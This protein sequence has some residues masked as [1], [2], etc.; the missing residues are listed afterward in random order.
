MYYSYWMNVC[1]VVSVTGIRDVSPPVV[2]GHRRDSRFVGYTSAG[3]HWRRSRND[4]YRARHSGANSWGICRRRSRD[5]LRRRAQLWHWGHRSQGM[6]SICS[7]CDLVL[8]WC[9]DEAP[10]GR[11]RQM[12]CKVDTTA[13][14]ETFRDPFATESSSIYWPINKHL[15]LLLSLLWLFFI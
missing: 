5:K 13:T 6:D 10:Q 3:S 1:L 9:N 4:K 14:S 12:C 11:K 8:G 2:V 15:K 7:S